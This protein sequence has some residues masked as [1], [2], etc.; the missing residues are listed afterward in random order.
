MPSEV[1]FSEVQRLLEQHGYELRRIVGSHHIFDKPGERSI[2]IP[3]HHGKVKHV[4]LR[5]ILKKLE[6]A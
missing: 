6:S 4:Y 1:R 3:V 2:P 5:Q